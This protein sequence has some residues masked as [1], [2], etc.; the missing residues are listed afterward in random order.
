[1][2]CQKAAQVCDDQQKG[3]IV[4][5]GILLHN[6][7]FSDAIA[8]SVSRIRSGQPAVIATV[9]V[10]FVMQAWQ[11]AELHRILLEADL[12]LADGA[13][14]V[15]LSSLFGPRLRE[16]VTGSDLTPLLAKECAKEQ[17]KVFLLGGQPGVAERAAAVLVK[18]NPC[19]RISGTSSP[20]MLPLSEMDTREI[21][22]EINAAQP[23]LLLVAMGAP[24]QEK[25]IHRN[26][27][28][29]EVPLAI[30]VGGT[31][32][33]IAGVQWRAP[34]LVQK[35]A[36]E[37]LWRLTTD[38]KRLFK[39]YF[40]NA[41]FLFNALLRI[42]LLR[43]YS[44]FEKRAPNVYC[45]K[46]GTTPQTLK[47]QTLPLEHIA[48]IKPPTPPNNWAV[49]DLGPRKW[50][51]SRQIAELVLAAL[52]FTR[53]QGHFSVLCSSCALQSLL[54]TCH[55]DRVMHIFPNMEHAVRRISATDSCGVPQG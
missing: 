9:N 47:A 23:D 2:F 37:W 40:L 27:P 32:D 46:P 49:I 50:L 10:D 7:T 29:W 55:L 34:R 35:M 39:R 18:K 41:I 13:P 14:L 52:S 42:Q 3:A 11:D 17:F 54:K 26:R 48:S 20:P 44:L 8:W 25:F 51:N 19:L 45:I 30:G 53:A 24:K 28:L 21:V 4:L 5:F 22:A 16:R 15:G 31:L 43:L 12:V 38:P 1:M 6:V 33:F 36:L